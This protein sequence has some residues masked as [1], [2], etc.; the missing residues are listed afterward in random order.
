MSSD[1]DPWTAG[2]TLLTLEIVAGQE[3]LVRLPD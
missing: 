2:E 3:T 1:V